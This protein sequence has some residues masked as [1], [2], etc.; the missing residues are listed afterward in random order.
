[1]TKTMQRLVWTY[2]NGCTVHTGPLSLFELKFDLQKWHIFQKKKSRSLSEMIAHHFTKCWFCCF[3]CGYFFMSLTSI[4]GESRK[5]ITCVFDSRC[6]F[7]LAA[8]SGTAFADFGSPS[9]PEPM[10]RNIFCW[11]AHFK[12]LFI[13]RICEICIVLF[14]SHFYF[15]K[16][17]N[18]A[19]HKFCKFFRIQFG[20]KLD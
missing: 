8:E 11:I 15:P 17:P 7:P 4:R 14:L 18:I 12:N 16:S 6:F 9:H 19:F 5:P 1:M 2:H 10:L 13:C 3:F 20:K